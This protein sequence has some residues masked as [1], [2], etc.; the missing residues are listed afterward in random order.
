MAAVP[1]SS[2]CFDDSAILAMGIAFDRACT[3]LRAFGTAPTVREII[4]ARIL[5]VAA[6]GVRNPEE[7]YDQ[8]LKAF[9]IEKPSI[10]SAA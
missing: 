3:A 2:D 1:D 4:A 7:L 6:L 8:A 5:E 10:V 9:D